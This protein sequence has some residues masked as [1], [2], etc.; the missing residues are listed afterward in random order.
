MEDAV[1]LARCLRDLPPA[2]ALRGFEA[3][4]RPRAERMVAQGF[5]ASAAKAPPAV[6]RLVR[7]LVMPVALRLRDPRAWGRAHTVEWDVPAPVPAG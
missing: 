6:G 5:A 2:D 1:V 4:R 3:L 7:D